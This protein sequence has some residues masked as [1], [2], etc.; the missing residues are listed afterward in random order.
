[1]YLYGGCNGG[2]LKCKNYRWIISNEGIIPGVWV[3]V[4]AITQLPLVAGPID[5]ARLG[6]IEPIYGEDM[7]TMRWEELTG[8]LP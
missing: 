6:H 8:A 3:A 2:V 4:N 5:T 7:S 1:M